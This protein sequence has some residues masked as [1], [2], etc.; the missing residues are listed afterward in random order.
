MYD[1]AV[2]HGTY[3]VIILVS[4]LW[5]NLNGKKKYLVFRIKKT[6]MCCV[7]IFHFVG[8]RHLHYGVM[9][10]WKCKIPSLHLA[11]DTTQWITI[12]PDESNWKWFG[13]VHV[14]VDDLGMWLQVTTLEFSTTFDNFDPW[15]LHQFLLWMN[16]GG[17]HLAH[18][19]HI[20]M[21]PMDSVILH[22]N[23]IQDLAI[24]CLCFLISTT[25]YK[26]FCKGNHAAY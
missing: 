19:S 24:G 23:E 9:H 14:V 5:S 18:C 7:K 22:R 10:H 21:L 6:G 8:M 25:F 4:F 17:G 3:Q 15:K 13:V 12:Q 2:I 11:G 20:F 16:E 1:V 26:A